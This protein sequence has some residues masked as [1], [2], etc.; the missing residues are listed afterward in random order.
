MTTEEKEIIDYATQQ[1]IYALQR[2]NPFPL[3][4]PDRLRNELSSAV[5]E[6]LRDMSTDINENLRKISEQNRLLTENASIANQLKYAQIYKA[7]RIS[8]AIVAAVTV[9]VIEVVKLFF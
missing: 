9:A 6:S 1:L 7:S 5:R 2:A 3:D 4:T 8:G